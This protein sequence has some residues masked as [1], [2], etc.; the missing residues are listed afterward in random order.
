LNLLPL[1]L[2]DAQAGEVPIIV[3]TQPYAGLLDGVSYVE[4]KIFD[5]GPH[6]LDKAMGYATEK[7]GPATCTQV[8][9]PGE[10][11]RRFTYEAAGQKS[12]VTTSWQKEM[13]KVAGRLPLW[14]TCPPLQF[15]RRDPVRETRLLRDVFP[16]KS[17]GRKPIM[18]LALDGKS[19]PF[20]HKALVRHLLKT[21]FG[22]SWRVVD[23]PKAARLYDLLALYEKAALLVAVDSAPLHLAWAARSLPVMALAQDKPLLWAGS[24]WRPNMVWY[25]RYGDWLDRWQE[26]L[27]VIS[28]H[29]TPI[30]S[31]PE[32]LVFS[33]YESRR[34]NA[35]N[36]WCDLPISIG[37]CGRD[38]AG[39]LQDPKRVPYLRDCLRMAI[40]KAAPGQRIILTRP[41]IQM[42]DDGCLTP[43]TAG[44]AYR[45]QGGTFAPIC[46]LFTAP[47]EWWQAALAEIPD[48]L[49]GSDYW[50]SQCLWAI[51]RRRGAVDITGA[52]SR[53]V[54]TKK[55]NPPIAFLSPRIVHNVNLWEKYKADQNVTARYEPVTKQVEALPLDTSKLPP[56]AYNPSIAKI[57][58]R[59]YMS[60]RYH[61][62]GDARTRLG[63]ATI[64]D[65]VATD[66]KD[67]E[68]AD[69]PGG[70]SLED[71]RLF[72]FHGETSLS[73]V[74][75][76]LADG[77]FVKQ[78]TCVVKYGQIESGKVGRAHQV[79]VGSNDGSRMEKNWCF[80]ESDENLFAV[81]FSE[82][83]HV[84]LQIQGDAIINEYKTPAARWPYG[85]LRGGSIVHHDGKLLRFF[86][87][88]TDIGPGRVESRYYVGAC[89]MEYRPPFKVLAVS[90]KPIIFGSEL[91]RYPIHHFKEN[92][93]FPT[94]AMAEGD[95]FLVSLGINDAA[96]AL[97]RI[98]PE[99][100]NL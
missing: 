72:R 78:P 89:L 3:T 96:C 8:N 40:Q 64:V 57:N 37:A 83:E 76:T 26:M 23:V 66:P 62:A 52:A 36:F 99:A 17:L 81:Y 43:P 29:P 30:P 14:D 2:A 90:K 46:D 35:A 56:F 25:C 68:F 100:L 48:L 94:G 20:A 38:S 15:D 44:Y 73:W 59:L 1:C 54:P 41:D 93:A 58:G 67:L 6:E 33:E 28:H 98:K 19:S 51:F 60:Y 85:M 22:D 63:M 13:W 42:V 88:R 5:S 97:V 21:T 9:G 45:M 79:K 49:L 27:D 10:L 47:R 65:G 77:Q 70:N 50:W 53:P 61:F 32:L 4:R 95:A 16:G 31:N 80:F 86:H 7:F 75:A 84:V 39:I 74:E 12:A 92:V 87:S 18:L 55:P 91:P 71:A 11:V 24:S 82:P 34:N 69:Q